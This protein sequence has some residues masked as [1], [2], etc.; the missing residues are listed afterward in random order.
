MVLTHHQVTADGRDQ[1][2]NG[3]GFD[4][5]ALDVVLIKTKHHPRSLCTG[6]D[7]L[8]EVSST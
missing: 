5:Q 2:M 8:N 3:A 4:I 7:F 6:G 1:G